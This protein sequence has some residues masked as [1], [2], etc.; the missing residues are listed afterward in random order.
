MSST[1]EEF[2]CKIDFGNKKRHGVGWGQHGVYSIFPSYFGH[3]S[4]VQCFLKS[5]G[6]RLELFMSATDLLDFLLVYH[7]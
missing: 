5:E 6:M 7:Y 4:E 1:E 2:Q 3:L